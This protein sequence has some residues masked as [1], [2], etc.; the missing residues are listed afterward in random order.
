MKVGMVFPGLPLEDGERARR[1]QGADC[2]EA[3][4]RAR[5]GVEG[6]ET[7]VFMGET[8]CQTSKAP[9]TPPGPIDLDVPIEVS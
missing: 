6:P 9:E 1:L 8:S 2:E 5:F 7:G 3:L 4:A